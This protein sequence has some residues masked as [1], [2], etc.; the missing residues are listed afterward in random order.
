MVIVDDEHFLNN[1]GDY[2]VVNKDRMF[3]AEYSVN[4]FAELI[5]GDYRISAID[6]I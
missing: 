5:V 6:W 4:S 3:D 1:F 2:P